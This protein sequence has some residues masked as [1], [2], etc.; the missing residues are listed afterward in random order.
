M[1]KIIKTLLTVVIDTREQTPFTFIGYPVVT[2]NAALK[3]GDYSLAGFEE[4]ICI[5]RKSL[6][7]LASC[8]TIGR[9]RFERELERMRTMECAAVIVEEPLI[10][11]QT[12]NYR[13]KLNVKSFEQSILSLIFRYRIPFLWGQ[14]RKHAENIAFNCLRHFYNKTLPDNMKIPYREY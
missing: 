14:N 7:D 8:M 2:K 9:D 3:T 6:G 1:P 10:N 5:E 4:R 12:G 13:S 11:I